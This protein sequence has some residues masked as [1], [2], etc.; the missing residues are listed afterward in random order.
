M[1][2]GRRHTTRRLP[3]PQIEDPNDAIIE[4]TTSAIC[5]TDR[6]FVR[7]SMTGM[8]EGRILGP[9]AVGVVQEIGPAVRNLRH[10]QGVVVPST[11]ACGSCAYCRQ[12]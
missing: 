9:E 5:G 4:I 3:D 10:S 7:G 8:S 12:G 11:V 6:H 1:A 2:R